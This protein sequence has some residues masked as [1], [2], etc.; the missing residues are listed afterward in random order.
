LTVSFHHALRMKRAQV[1]IVSEMD[2]RRIWRDSMSSV[3]FGGLFLWSCTCGWKSVR[4][5]RRYMWSVHFLRR[6]VM[7]GVVSSRKAVCRD[8]GIMSETGIA[9]WEEKKIHG[10]G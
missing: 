7:D 4:P 6:L 2:D 3:R 9:D 10:E 1:I 8:P 5:G